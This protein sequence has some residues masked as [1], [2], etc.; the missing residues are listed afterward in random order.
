MCHTEYL[1]GLCPLCGQ[2]RNDGCILVTCMEEMNN[3]LSSPCRIVVDDLLKMTKYNLTRDILR[4]AGISEWS[5]NII[6]PKLSPNGGMIIPLHLCYGCKIFVNAAYCQRV[7]EEKHSVLMAVNSLEASY[8]D[9]NSIRSPNDIFAIMS[10]EAKYIR[11][12]PIYVPSYTCAEIFHGVDM[13][14]YEYNLL[15]PQCTSILAGDHTQWMLKDD[16]EKNIILPQSGNRVIMYNTSHVVNATH[17]SISAGRIYNTNKYYRE[18]TAMPHI[19]DM[20]TSSEADKS[21]LIRR[22]TSDYTYSNIASIREINPLWDGNNSSAYPFQTF[23]KIG[24]GDACN[25]YDVFSEM[26]IDLCVTNQYSV[27]DGI[28]SKSVDKVYIVD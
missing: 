27:L 6:L 25:T 18:S 8:V 3:G 11:N 21:K 12:S 4:G 20:F 2:Y 28:P 16:T 9:H 7:V 15:S 13:N 23:M 14:K 26:N 10:Y 22:S 1:P 19:G 17:T 5:R 24:L